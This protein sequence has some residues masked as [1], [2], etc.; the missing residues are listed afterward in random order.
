MT[1]ADRIVL[2]APSPAVWF[3]LPGAHHDIGRF[4]TPAGELTGFYAN[5]LTPV[6]I[7]PPSGGADVWR[8]TDLFLDVFLTP[9]GRVHVL[10]EDELHGAVRRGWVDRPTART[11]R[12]EAARLARLARTGAWPP[13]IVRE[14]TVERA[15]AVAGS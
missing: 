1:V 15:R 14:W 4:H 3:T 7:L 13:P 10:D 9:E 11:A 5:I 6:E 12:L 8:T 2:E